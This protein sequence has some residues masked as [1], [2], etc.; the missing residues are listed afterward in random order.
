MLKFEF[1]LRNNSNNDVKAKNA[2]DN[3]DTS[4]SV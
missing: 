1:E 3:D 2:S 4:W